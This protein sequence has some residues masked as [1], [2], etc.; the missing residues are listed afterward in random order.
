M[1]LPD[2]FKLTNSVE[3]ADL[4]NAAP[5]ANL[6]SQTPEG[7]RVDHIPLMLV[8]ETLIGHIA[9][10]NDLHRL[11]ADGQDMLAAFQGADAYI[12]PNWYPSKA[13]THKVVPTWNYEVV[14]VHGAVKFHHDR[15]S[16]L[17]VL[18]KLTKMMETRTNGAD[19]WRMAD[20]P[21]GFMDTM[22]D[23]I[24]AFEIGIMRVLGKAKLSQN[25]TDADRIGAMNGLGNHPIA[26]RMKTAR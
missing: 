23:G 26:A 7:L 25:K 1:Y 21:A 18:G 2:H 16:K 13:D 24:V 14:H 6:V 17:A 11:V 20:A 3:I 4:I 5:L 9:F 19:A 10:A 12:S 8:G 22:L 15:K